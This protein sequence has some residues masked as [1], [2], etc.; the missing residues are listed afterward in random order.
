MPPS[1]SNTTWMITNKRSAA[2]NDTDG[3]SAASDESESLAVAAIA[4][5]ETPLS[6]NPG[7][8]SCYGNESSSK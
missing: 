1:E 6:R 7:R 8:L 4:R 2:A 3:T 5:G